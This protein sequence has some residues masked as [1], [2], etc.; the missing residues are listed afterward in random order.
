MS[1]T[2]AQGRWW[3]ETIVAGLYPGR[4][5]HDHIKAQAPGWRALTTELYFPGEPGNT[6]DSLFDCALLMRVQRFPEGRIAN[7]DIVLDIA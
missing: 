3:F 4:T 7:F 1:L 5:R 2:D 6:R